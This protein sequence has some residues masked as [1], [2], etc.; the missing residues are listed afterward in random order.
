M[1]QAE[2]DNEANNKARDFRNQMYE[3]VRRE[4]TLTAGSYVFFPELDKFLIEYER[5]LE[6]KIVRVLER[7]VVGVAIDSLIKKGWK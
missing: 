2:I 5:Y 7:E 4:I 3:L 1:I 6:A